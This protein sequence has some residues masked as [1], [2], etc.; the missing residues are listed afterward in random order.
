MKNN[1][2]FLIVILGLFTSTS[3][4][5]ANCAYIDNKVV[6]SDIYARL[7]NRGPNMLAVYGTVEND[8]SV[9]HILTGVSSAGAKN[10]TFMVYRQDGGAGPITAHPIPSITIPQEGGTYAWVMGGNHITL[11]GYDAKTAG[12]KLQFGTSFDSNQNVDLTFTF[13]DGCQQIIQKVPIKDRMQ[14]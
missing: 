6:F 14:D 11:S 4:C 9:P 13:A 7:V 12:K 10:S 5:A 2:S 3:L 8:D 1:A